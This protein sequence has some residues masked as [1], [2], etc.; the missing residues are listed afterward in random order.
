M[1]LTNFDAPQFISVHGIRQE[2]WTRGQGRPIVFLRPGVGL[3]GAEECLA[4]LAEQGS[5]FAPS[6]PGFG[7]SDLPD[8]MSTVDDLAYVYLDVLEQL[9]LRGVILVGSSFGGWVA[10]EMAVKSTERIS[11]VIF[12]DSIGIKI[13]G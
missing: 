4:L 12:A 5:V 8:W 9:N 7:R 11:C 10:A 3:L 2:V 6:H 1:S 13:G